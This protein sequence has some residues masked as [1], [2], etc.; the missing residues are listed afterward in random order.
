MKNNLI[1]ELVMIVLRQAAQ[2]VQDLLDGKIDVSKID[3]D[4]ARAGLI[5][6]PRLPEEGDDLPAD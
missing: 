3:L 2:A 5:A 1:V 6:L 4:K